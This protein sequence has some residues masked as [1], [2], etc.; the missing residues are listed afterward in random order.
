M[1]THNTIDYGF[2]ESFVQ[3]TGAFPLSFG[4]QFSVYHLH[5]SL[6]WRL[7]GDKIKVNFGA[8]HPQYSRMGSNLCLIPPGKKELN[9][10]LKHIWYTAEKRLLKADELI[11]IG[12]SLN[13]KDYELMDLLKKYVEANGSETIK[14]IHNNLIENRFVRN[15][16]LN[17][18]QNYI[19]RGF[20]DYQFGFNLIGPEGSSGAIEFIFK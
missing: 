12:C 15:K 20:K 2:K 1:V 9:P 5:G 7:M 6:N 19:G 10:I 17:Y 3:S 18:F 8:I 4:K 13:P 11:I 16:F 14:F